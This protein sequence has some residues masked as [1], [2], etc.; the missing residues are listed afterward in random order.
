MPNYQENITKHTKRK[1]KQKMKRQSKHH[2]QIHM[3]GCWSF[4]TGNSKQLINMLIALVDRIESRQEKMHNVSR[5]M[6][7]LRIKKKH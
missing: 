2:N 3:A 1:T 6:E 7:I 4:Q 5:E